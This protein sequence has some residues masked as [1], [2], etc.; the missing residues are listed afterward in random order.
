MNDRPIYVEKHLNQQELVHLDYFYKQQCLG[1]K[2]VFV[3]NPF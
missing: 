2:L 1:L 3:L